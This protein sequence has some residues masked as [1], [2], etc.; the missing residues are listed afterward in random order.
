VRDKSCADHFTHAFLLSAAYST[1]GSCE[2][3]KKAGA[4]LLSGFA[5]E[6]L[7]RLL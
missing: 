4:R 7:Q 6:R 1:H 2:V 5:K 3:R